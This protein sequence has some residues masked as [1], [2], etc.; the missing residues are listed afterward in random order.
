MN[1]KLIDGWFHR[2]KKRQKVCGES[3]AVNP[4]TITDYRSNK[5]RSLLEE[6]APQDIF[7]CDETGVFYNMLLD[8]TLSFPGDTCSG[9]KRSKE[10]I[11]VMVG[12]NTVG[13]EKLPLLIIGRSENPRCFKSTK[14]ISV[15]CYSRSIRH[16][17]VLYRSH[18][19]SHSLLCID[20]R[21]VYP[22][23]VLSA[24]NML[25]E[26]LRATYCTAEDIAAGKSLVAN[27]RNNGIDI[28]STITFGDFARSKLTMKSCKKYLRNLLKVSRTQTTT[29]PTA[30]SYQQ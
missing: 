6:Y 18:L 27:L 15:V 23:E 29:M 24:A 3:G 28:P 4:A 17:K 9:G 1:V 12:A 19:L 22:A 8:R 20:N 5:L 21:K 26:A 10:R 2:F 30:R 25:A 14:K 16:L 7:T 13:D 11:S